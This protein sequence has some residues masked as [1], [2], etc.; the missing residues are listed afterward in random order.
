MHKVDDHWTVCSFFFR[1]KLGTT[2]YDKKFAQKLF[3][4]KG[5]AKSSN[6]LVTLHL[7]FSICTIFLNTV[8]QK[9]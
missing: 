9:C 7:A 1:K 8:S 3:L 6:G 5:K 2:I 4:K